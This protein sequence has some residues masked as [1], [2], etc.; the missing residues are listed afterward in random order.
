MILVQSNLT[1]LF[2][3]CVLFLKNLL[4]APLEATFAHFC[5]HPVNLLVVFLNDLCNI[6]QIMRDWCP[7]RALK[8]LVNTVLLFCSEHDGA[9]VAGTRRI[10]MDTRMASVAVF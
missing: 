7:W 3:S 10:K 9:V 2:F 8:R 4:D 1:S 5:D 6:G